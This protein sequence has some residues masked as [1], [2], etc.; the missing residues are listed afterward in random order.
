MS[1]NKTEICRE[2]LWVRK[3]RKEQRMRVK[4]KIEEE[5]ESAGA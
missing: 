1:Y 2:Q 4:E 5:E 3:Y